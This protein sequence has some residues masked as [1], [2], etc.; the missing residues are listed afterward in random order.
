MAEAVVDFVKQKLEDALNGP[1]KDALIKEGQLLYGVN[2]KAEEVQRELGRIKSFLKDADSK[3]SSEERVRNWIKEVRSVA[4]A[5]EDA[6]DNF[7]A[8]V[9]SI[10]YK[11]PGFFNALKRLVKKPTLLWALHTF[12]SE[13]EAIQTRIKEIS[14]AKMQFG[15]SNLD[16][17][18][19]GK[20]RPPIRR[21]IV[22][23]ID[24][25]E[26]IGFESDKEEIISRLVHD[27]NSRRSVVSIV[28]PGGIGKTTLAQT[29]YNSVK[30][31]FEFHIWLSV[32]QEV[33]LID[34]LKKMHEKLQPVNQRDHHELT[35]ESL[36]R[37]IHA[38]M[39]ENKYL[40]FL[41]DVWTED[42]W[43]QLQM[44]CPDAKNGSRV[45]ITS[46]FVNVAKAADPKP[47]E[48]QY[49]NEEQS[50]QLLLKKAFPLKDPNE[51]YPQDLS[52]LAKEYSKKCGGLPLQL[53]ELGN[54]LSR[55]S[56]DYQTWHRFMRSIDWVTDGKNCFD[57]IAISYE[58][59]PLHLKSCFMSFSVF[60]ENYEI[61]AQ[62]LISYWSVEGFIPQEGRGTMYDKAQGYLDDLAQRCMIQVTK[63]NTTTG[64]IER[65][66]VHTLL[67]ILA[68]HEAREKNFITVFW[69]Q[70][71]NRKEAARHASFHLYTPEMQNN[72]TENKDITE[73]AGP[74]VRSL[75]FFGKILPIR[76]RMKLL[77]VLVVYH[78]SVTFDDGKH[79]WL[80]NL[81]SLRH[82]EFRECT[83]ENDTLPESIDCLHHLEYLDLTDTKIV[84]LPKSIKC[85]EALKLVVNCVESSS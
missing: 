18:S 77:K 83:L 28:G 10:N 5:I 51:S 27:E 68:V 65:W 13:M 73:Y 47:S 63:R 46:R 64:N 59:L 67:R 80:E 16:D 79:T 11:E 69:K 9:D 35:E 19:S 58:H 71:D 25:T 36:V 23:D 1:V 38:S 56:P 6:V 30:D 39:K 20:S 50:V 55:K 72:F 17:G 7:Q 75:M 43:Y 4:Y 61:N 14:D 74:N 41:D 12:G 3:S 57:T 76:S 44:V 31:R 62:S 22:A 2:D 26:V 66:R 24:E 60:P 32:T 48:L 37:E 45:L 78:T 21:L 70:E 84:D 42:V 8:D 82:L 40:V 85:N 49:L 53:A 81:I 54:L 33:N 34:L 52:E 29:V 15:V